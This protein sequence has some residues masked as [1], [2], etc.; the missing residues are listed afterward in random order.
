MSTWDQSVFERRAQV[1][2]GTVCVCHQVCLSNRVQQ[3]GAGMAASRV[4]IPYFS[5]R[6]VG[7]ALLTHCGVLLACVSLKLSSVGVDCGYG[8][9]VSSHG[10]SCKRACALQR[11]VAV[12]VTALC[13]HE[14]DPSL[15]V[16]WIH[17]QCIP[18]ALCCLCFTHSWPKA[19]S[20]AVW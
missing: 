15:A 12:A 10:L 11:C 4:C 13:C 5:R 19:A 16:A 14:L 6:L 9:A 8:A 20:A 7:P 1:G 17:M 18:L 2:A 3:L